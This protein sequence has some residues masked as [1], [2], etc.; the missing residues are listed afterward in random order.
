MKHKIKLHCCIHIEDEMSMRLF[1]IFI[2]EP[3]IIKNF[4]VP[5][6]SLIVYLSLYVLKKIHTDLQLNFIEIEKKFALLF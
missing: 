2:N 6:S 1:C 4:K 3:T 5:N